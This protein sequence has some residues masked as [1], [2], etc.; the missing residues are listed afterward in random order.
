MYGN[1][2]RQHLLPLMERVGE[3]DPACAEERSAVIKPFTVTMFV[4]VGEVPVVTHG[5]LLCTCTQTVL[6]LLLDLQL[7]FAFWLNQPI[8]R[9][10]QPRRAPVIKLGLFS[11]LPTKKSLGK[12][13]V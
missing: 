6:S 2:E 3:H 7:D 1:R 13:A 8:C 11:N 5:N 9:S 12:R 4:D 10:K